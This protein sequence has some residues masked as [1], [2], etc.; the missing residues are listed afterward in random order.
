MKNQFQ[1][2]WSRLFLT[3]RLFL[4]RNSIRGRLDARHGHFGQVNFAE[5]DH[6][7]EQMT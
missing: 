1:I 5:R 4:S 3:R 2:A 6:F 7:D